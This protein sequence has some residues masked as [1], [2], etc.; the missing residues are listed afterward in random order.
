MASFWYTND[1]DCQM[2]MQSSLWHLI[3]SILA[4][5][6]GVFA[7]FPWQIMLTLSTAGYSCT[8]G[9][10][11]MLQYFICDC[12]ASAW[13][14]LRLQLVLKRNGFGAAQDK[15]FIYMS[16]GLKSFVSNLAPGSWRT[17]NLLWFIPKAF[18]LEQRK[19]MSRVQSCEVYIFSVVCFP[20]FLM[21]TYPYSEPGSGHSGHFDSPFSRSNTI[22]YNFSWC[23]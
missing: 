9:P 4:M 7:A 20:V 13:L 18:C 16:Y 3:Q 6:L 1:Y 11:S 12:Q 15:Q 23:L 2:N 22:N 14:V 21:T 19:L 5:F 10:Y 8:A 17:F